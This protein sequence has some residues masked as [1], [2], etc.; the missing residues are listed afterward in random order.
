MP[1]LKTNFHGDKIYN[2]KL[3]ISDV[4][5][6]QILVRFIIFLESLDA[7]RTLLLVKTASTVKLRKI[8]DLPHTSLI[9]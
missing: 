6:G 2:L 8:G 1:G 7:L 5:K 9:C 4:N 3:H